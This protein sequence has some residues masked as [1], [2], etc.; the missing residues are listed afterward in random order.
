MTSEDFAWTFELAILTDQF[1]LP[2]FIHNV[3]H[4]SIYALVELAV[5]AIVDA[6]DLLIQKTVNH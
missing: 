5:A 3:R 6:G 4:H 1:C 2:T